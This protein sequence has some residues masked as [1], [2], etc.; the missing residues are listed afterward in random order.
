MIAHISPAST[1]FEESRS[2]LAYAHRAK[3][4]R[5]A[6]GPGAQAPSSLGTSPPLAPS[7]SS[8]DPTAPQ[9]GGLEVFVLTLPHGCLE[10][11]D[12]LGHCSAGCGVLRTGSMAMHCLGTRLGDPMG[13]QPCSAWGPCLGILLKD[14]LG[15]LLHQLCPAQGPHLGPCLGPGCAGAMGCSQMPHPR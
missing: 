4:I 8:P 9:Q 10:Q 5:T 7:P 11:G 6:V 12:R 15:D 3:S 1:A 14:I 13:I 2:T